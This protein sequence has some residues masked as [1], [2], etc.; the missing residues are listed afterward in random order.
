[1]KNYLTT[2]EAIKFAEE[3][4]NIIIPTSTVR[5]WILNF[6]IGKKIGGRWFVDRQKFSNILKGD[7]AYDTQG[8]PEK[9]KD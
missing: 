1:M 6:D 9:Q 8:R 7:I 3:E 2:A 4:A 5:N